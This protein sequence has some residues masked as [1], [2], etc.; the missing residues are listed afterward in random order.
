[1]YAMCVISATM[2]TAVIVAVA[3]LVAPVAEVAQIGTL[4]SDEGR[5]LGVHHRPLHLALHFPPWTVGETIATERPS[6]WT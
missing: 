6:L 1:M 5:A 2:T 4:T 3:V